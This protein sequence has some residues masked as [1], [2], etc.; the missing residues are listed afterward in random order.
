MKL[1]AFSILA[2]AGYILLFAWYHKQMRKRNAAIDET[3]QAQS[4]Q[5]QSSSVKKVLKAE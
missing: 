4:A 1:I 3:I 5:N 2:L